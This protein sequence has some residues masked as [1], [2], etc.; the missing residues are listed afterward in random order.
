MVN[1]E[2][3]IC[4]PWADPAQV[5]A[6]VQD[7]VRFGPYF[8]WHV[9]PTTAVLSRSELHEPAQL[10]SLLDAMGNSIGSD[11]GRV[12]A[13]TLQYGFAARCWSLTLGV[14]QHG[15]VV[16][17]L[18]G[19][20][21]VA[22]PSGSVD[23][24]LSD[25]RGWDGNTLSV[26]EVADV[27]ATTVISEQFERFH[28]ALRAVVRVADGLLW[29]NAASALSSGARRVAAGRS[30]DR[31]TPVAASLLARHPLAGKMSAAPTGPWRRNTCCLWYRTRDHTKCSDCPL[32]D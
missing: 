6:A 18:G 17:D 8:G 23:L 11:E 24:T 22:N 4:A 21:Y 2:S 5:Q 13:S 14:W 28:A 16:L 7:A 20:G 25:F 29:G 26:D 31:V 30:D 19:L 10:R 1:I 15:G 3:E 12:V 9:G 32:V 27:M